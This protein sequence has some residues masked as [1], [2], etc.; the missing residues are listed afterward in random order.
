MKKYTVS[1]EDAV[2]EVLNGEDPYVVAFFMEGDYIETAER[3][4][5]AAYD[6]LVE[7]YEVML[8]SVSEEDLKAAVDELLA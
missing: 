4:K 2:K 1:F 5:A 6:S 8:D 3:V 7:A